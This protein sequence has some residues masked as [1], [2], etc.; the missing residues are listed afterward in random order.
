[1]LFSHFTQTNT[2]KINKTCAVIR[3]AHSQ[4]S[5]AFI[6]YAHSQ[7]FGKPN[8]L[9]VQPICYIYFCSLHVLVCKTLREYFLVIHI[10]DWFQSNRDIQHSC[11]YS[12][13]RLF[14]M[15]KH[16]L[17]PF[18]QLII[19]KNVL[20]KNVYGILKYLANETSI[21]KHHQTEQKV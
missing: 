9:K 18:P 12:N 6:R 16:L 4:Q 11:N 1:M 13:G 21:W 10:I 19:K 15:I 17:I 8:N 3:Y 7:Q 2:N 14:C 5:C 20:S